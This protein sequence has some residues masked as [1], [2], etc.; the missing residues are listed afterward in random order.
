M[1]HNLVGSDAS[2]LV[3]IYDLNSEF[4]RL[5]AA[6]L[7]QNSSFGVGPQFAQS[8]VEGPSIFPRTSAGLRLAVKP[9]ANS[10][11]RAAVL[12]GVPVARPDGSHG[13][14][15]RGDGLLMVGEFAWLSRSAATGMLPPA[16]RDRIGRFSSL[17]PY[18][19]KLTAG[20][21]HYTGRHADL[22]DN[23]P[24]GVPLVRRGSS[25]G[26]VVAERLLLGSDDAPGRRLAAFAQAGFADARTNRFGSYAGAGVVGTGW[27]PMKDS[28][29]IGLSVAHARDGNH[30]H[31]NTDP[32]RANALVLTLRFEVAM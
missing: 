32:S 30:Y 8:G 27:R 6:G 11:L 29:Q 12:D 23:D 5:E 15:R 7:F 19:D 9:T 1:Q 4:Y 31:P 25:G 16:T 20:L 21:W 26:Y 17:T 18:R 22:S 3:G 28:D 2:L 10:V 14:F 13:T 24:S